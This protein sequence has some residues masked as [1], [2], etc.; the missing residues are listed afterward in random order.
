[1]TRAV[2]AATKKPGVRIASMGGRC[3][4]RNRHYS[5]AFSLRFSRTI[6]SLALEREGAL[7]RRWRKE[8]SHHLPMRLSAAAP[9]VFA[10]ATPTRD[11]RHRGSTYRR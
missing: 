2:R 8:A 10:P 11:E 6:Y 4:A 1:M 3:H 5:C 9:L 7:K